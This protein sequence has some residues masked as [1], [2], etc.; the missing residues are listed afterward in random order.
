MVNLLALRSI[1]K[2][3]K[4]DVGETS[5]IVESSTTERD[6]MRL[7]LQI[8]QN[9][10]NTLIGKLLLRQAWYRSRSWLL[11]SFC[12]RGWRSTQYLCIIWR[13]QVFLSNVWGQ[14]AHILSVWAFSGGFCYGTRWLEGENTIIKVVK[15]RTVK[16]ILYKKFLVR[17]KWGSLFENHV[18]FWKGGDGS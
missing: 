18:Y 12:M 4:Q 10:P 3:A 6:K 11:Y 15:G 16:T 8:A 17:R 1:K 9:Q 13:L 5:G 7:S 14:N 2:E